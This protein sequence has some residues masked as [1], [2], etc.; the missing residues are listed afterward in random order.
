MPA[1]PR[2]QLDHGISP[3]DPQTRKYVIPARPERWQRQLLADRRLK[4]A[5]DECLQMAVNDPSF[6]R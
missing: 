5:V 6:A 2:R 4:A 1:L 3:H